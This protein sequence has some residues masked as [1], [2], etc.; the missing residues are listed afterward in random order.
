ME[1]VSSTYNM[2][3][4]RLFQ[5]V[6]SFIYMRNNKGPRIEHCGTPIVRVNVLD[7]ATLISTNCLQ[8]P[9]YLSKSS[10]ATPFIP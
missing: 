2:K 10:C 3:S 5:S 8:L 9:M 1:E 7:F 4:K 6:I